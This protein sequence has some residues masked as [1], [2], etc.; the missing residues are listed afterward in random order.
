MAKIPTVKKR[1]KYIRGSLNLGIIVSLLSTLL[2]TKSLLLHNNFLFVKDLDL[3]LCDPFKD[4]KD[5]VLLDKEEIVMKE[6]A[7]GE[8]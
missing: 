7:F 3:G 4:V 6:E 1:R 2:L 5:N 8:E